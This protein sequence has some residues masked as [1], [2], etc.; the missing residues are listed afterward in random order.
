MDPNMM[1]NPALGPQDKLRIMQEVKQGAQGAAMYA[2]AYPQLN[3]VWEDVIRSHATEM[4]LDQLRDDKGL[5]GVKVTISPSA[6]TERMAQFIKMDSL[7]TKY[8]NIIPIDV[9]IDLLDLPQGDE[10]KAKIAASQQAQSAQAP[11]GPR[12]VAA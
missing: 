6:P 7:M 9:F 10:I 4:L 11:Q 3:T 5:Y 2:Q 1:A 12:G 8:G